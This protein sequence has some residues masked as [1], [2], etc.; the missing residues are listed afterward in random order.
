MPLSLLEESRLNHFTLFGAHVAN[1]PVGVLS[2]EPGENCLP[3][4]R[5]Y[6]RDSGPDDPR[7]E[8]VKLMVLG[9]GRIGKTQLCRNLTGRS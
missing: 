1:V 3:S 7:I 2:S 6:F 9:N 5:A 8:D 4:L